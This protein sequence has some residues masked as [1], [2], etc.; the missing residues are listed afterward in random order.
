MIKFKGFLAANEPNPPASAPSVE[1]WL[2]IGIPSITYNGP[3]PERIEVVPRIRILIPVP[4]SPLPGVIATPAAR[5]CNSCSGEAITPLL[6]SFAVKA[7][8]PPVASFL[9]V[10]P[11]PT[12]T[13]SS[14]A[15]LSDNKTTS[16][17]DLLPTTIDC[18]AN[19][20]N[21]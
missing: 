6:K 20:T 16:I 8:T 2:S 13:T 17:T 9:V 10:V 7:T 3:F 15:L 4:G 5:P 12:T 21:E 19:P 14:K 11:Y 1:V 18:L